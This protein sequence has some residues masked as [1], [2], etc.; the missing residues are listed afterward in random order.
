MKN[1]SSK[2]V[3]KLIAKFQSGLERELMAPSDQAARLNIKLGTLRTR[4]S[5]GQLDPSNYIHIEAGYYQY[6]D[7]FDDDPI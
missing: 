1:I 2:K 6:A 4:R 5:R 3:V 7:S